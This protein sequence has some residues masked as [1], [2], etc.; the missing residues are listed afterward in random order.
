MYSDGSVYRATPHGPLEHSGY[1]YIGRKTELPG[2]RLL[3]WAGVL[4]PNRASEITALGSFRSKLS[5]PRELRSQ[6]GSDPTYLPNTG[7]T[8]VFELSIPSTYATRRT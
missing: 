5:Q 3:R 8:P 4:L 7:V 1:I 2:P 6:E